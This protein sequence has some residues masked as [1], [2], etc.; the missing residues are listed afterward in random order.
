MKT[1]IYVDVLIAVNILITY[2][3]L[4]CTRV[5]V[6]SDTNKWGVVIATFFGGVSSL[7]IFLENMPIVFSVLLKILGVTV[8]SFSAFLPES[9]TMF[10]KTALAFLFVNFLFGGVMYFVEITFKP[11]DIIY[12]N[13][14]VYFD[15]SVLFLV[16]VTLICYGLL[17]LFDFFLKKRS[18]EKTLYNATIYFRN[19]S[20]QVKALYDTGNHLTDG[21]EGKPVIIVTLNSIKEFF[22]RSETEYFKSELITPEVPSTLKSI[23]R[24]VPCSSVNGN[25][26]LKG[27]VPEKMIIEIDDFKLQ[28]AFFIVAVTNNPLS[29]GEYDCILN[30]A[31]FERSSKINENKICK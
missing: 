3:M 21:I 18:S 13:G 5:I 31:I 19:K 12:I 10:L 15:I 22:S 17:L 23:V 11:T 29:L 27:F 25:S 28:T 24:I 7:V 8:I 9:K 2:V 30:S 16:S 20:V 6:K 4:V 26:L 14:T 1:V